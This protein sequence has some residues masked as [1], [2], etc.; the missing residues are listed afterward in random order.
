MSKVLPELLKRMARDVNVR[1]AFVLD[2]EMAGDG[3]PN[4]N[5]MGFVSMFLATMGPLP[6]PANGRFVN[7]WHDGKW[8]AAP[9]F[10]GDDHMNETMR[11]GTVSVTCPVCNGL[12]PENR[13]DFKPSSEFVDAI[14]SMVNSKENKF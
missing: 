5:G 9:S 1:R 2:Y 11:F 3:C 8:W 6:E 12:K 10:N 7:K 4:C 13:T 14:R